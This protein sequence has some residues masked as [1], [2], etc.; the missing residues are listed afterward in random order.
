M[1]GQMSVWDY[2]FADRKHVEVIDY[3]DTKPFILNIHY[4]RRMPCIQY[5]FGLREGGA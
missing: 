2:V 1:E 4:A 3:E 5:A